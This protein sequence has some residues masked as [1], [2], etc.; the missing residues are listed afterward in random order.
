[1]HGNVWEWCLDLYADKYVYSNHDG[2][3][4]V[5][6][7]TNRVRK[8]GSWNNEANA[9]RASMRA[10]SASDTTGSYLGFRVISLCGD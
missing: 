5:T 9:A 3:V 1:M 7:G 4:N 10:S 2:A 8:G 6:T